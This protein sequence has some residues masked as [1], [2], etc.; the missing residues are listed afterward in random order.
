MVGLKLVLHYITETSRNKGKNFV[1]S[2]VGNVGGYEMKLVHS[3]E[4]MGSFYWEHRNIWKPLKIRASEKKKDEILRTLRSRLIRAL[5][6]SQTR[7]QIFF[8]G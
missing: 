8:T 6:P 1:G 3:E 2:R 7:V 4:K 5:P